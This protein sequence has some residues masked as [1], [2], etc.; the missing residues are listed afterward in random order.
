[1]TEV[2][3]NRGIA[4]TRTEE[5]AARSLVRRMLGAAKL[6]IATYDEV[7]RDEA[8]TVQAA[9]VVAIVAMAQAIGAAGEDGPGVVGGLVPAYAGWVLWSGVAYLIGFRLLGGTATWGQLLRALGFAQTPSVLA[10][11]GIV[12]GM[13]GPAGAVVGVWLLATG[14]VAIRH[15]LGLGTAK[16]IAIAVAGW[17]IAHILIIIVHEL[18]G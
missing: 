4:L 13:A 11:V 17:I 14:V 15:V 10:I 6:D 2:P 9:V 3:G 16:A 7:R 12:P 18:V 8:A 5:G 1:M